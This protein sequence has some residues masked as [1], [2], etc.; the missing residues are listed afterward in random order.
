MENNLS[1]RVDLLL[2]V[3]DKENWQT[4]SRIAQKIDEIEPNV[5]SLL[6]LGQES[7]FATDRN[8]WK[9]KK[10]AT[11]EMVREYRDS[12]IKGQMEPESAQTMSEKQETAHQPKRKV[13]RA[14]KKK[15]KKR[16]IQLASYPITQGEGTD[17]SREELSTTDTRGNGFHYGK[18]KLY[19]GPEGKYWTDPN[20]EKRE[21]D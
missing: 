18:K 19:S 3:M 15:K 20:F 6:L 14:N 8:S 21:S 13:N 1:L 16:H 9:I 11:E 2:S 4:A 17:Y 5:I 10:R 7:I 12:A